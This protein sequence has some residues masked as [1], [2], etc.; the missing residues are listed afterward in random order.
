[1]HRRDLTK[2]QKALIAA[3]R[4][5]YHKALAKKREKARKSKL[6][7]SVTCIGRPH[8]SSWGHPLGRFGL[9]DRRQLAIRL[10]RFGREHRMHGEMSVVPP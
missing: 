9:F 3:R 6:A 7:P 1:V 8:L 5:E 4:L 2:E 10:G